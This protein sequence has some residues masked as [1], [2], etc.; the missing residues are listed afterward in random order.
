MVKATQSNLINNT[1]FKFQLYY[2]PTFRRYENF[3]PISMIQMIPTFLKNPFFKKY[4]EE[5][6]NRNNTAFVCGKMQ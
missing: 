5:K 2:S 6:R 1:A 3:C 4:S